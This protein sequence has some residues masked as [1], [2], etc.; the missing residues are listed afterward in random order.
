MKK[1][2]TYVFVLLMPV[3]VVFSIN[4]F[5]DKH[6]SSK[7]NKKLIEDLILNDS[8][9][10]KTSLSDRQFVKNRIKIERVTKIFFIIIVK[11]LCLVA[12]EVY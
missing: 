5:I 1:F 9:V 7:F 6:N 8:L 11:I 12:Q 10:I 3:F 4:I 2:S